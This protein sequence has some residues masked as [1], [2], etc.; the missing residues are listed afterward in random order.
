M[1]SASASLSTAR[2][3]MARRSPNLARARNVLMKS[4]QRQYQ[5]HYS[6]EVPKEPKPFSLTKFIFKLSLLTAGIYGTA[7]TAA[8]LYEPLQEPYLEYFPYGEQVMD[9]IDYAWKHK[10]EVKDFDYKKYYNTTYS[11]VASSINDTAAKVGLDDYINIPHKGI[12]SIPVTP[13]TQQKLAEDKKKEEK[14]LVLS[15][16]DASKEKKITLPSIS[17]KSDDPRITNLVASLNSLISEF[18]SSKIN[19]QSNK[20]IESIVSSVNELSSKFDNKEINVLAEEKVASIKQ[21]LEQEKTILV[22]NLAKTAEQ[23]K[24]ELEAKHREVLSKEISETEKTLALEY[25]NKLK[26][27]EL[28][29][30]D[31]FSKNVSSRIESERNNKLKD[32]EI[33]SK[34]IDEIEKF[35]LQLSKVATSYTTFKEVRKS[36]SKVRELLNSNVSS[37]IRGENLVAEINNLKELTKPLDNDL[38]NVTLESLPS[39]K[40]LLINGGVLTQAQILTRWELLAPELRSVS[41]LP[42]NPGILG[43]ASSKIFSKFLWSKSGVPVQNDNDLIGNDVESVIAR[44]NNHLQKNQLD[45]AVEEVTHLKGVARELANDWLVDTR[46][47]LEIQFLVDLLSTEVNIS[48]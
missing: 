26:K 8:L 22:S 16:S 7:A 3:N 9:K 31:K 4:N 21:K 38:I 35:E 11:Q 28:D 1:L 20:V 25:D 2:T 19:E 10:Q 14:F 45:N 32:L 13:S 18:N 37:N 42:E 29:L 43:Y 48:A 23:T 36:I 30:V 40:E 33:L 27:K 15:N 44:V 47:K 34:R 6:S 12:E 41:L 39:E 5:R 24:Q 17:I 46:R